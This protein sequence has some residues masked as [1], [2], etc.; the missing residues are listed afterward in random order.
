MSGLLLFLLAP[1]SG[2]LGADQAQVVPSTKSLPTII[3]AATYPGANALV[4]SDSVARPIESQL[5]GLEKV[6]HLISRCT[7][8][9]KYTLLVTLE[10]GVDLNIAQVLVQNR[11]SLAVPTLPAVIQEHG[12]TIRKHS[13]GAFLF[14]TLHSPDASL[15]ALYLSN[16]AIIHV[17]DELARLPE[18]A[19]V[20]LLGARDYAFRV[21]LD[22]Q[23]LAA[24]SLT[25]DDV[26]K[27]LREL[28]AQ[29]RGKSEA[30]EKVADA[31]IKTG[32]GGRLVRLRDV[33]RV[34][35]GSA[36][37]KDNARLDGKP[38]VVLSLAASSRTNERALRA[39]VLKRMAE[40]KKS[41]PPGIDYSINIDLTSDN[42]SA[43]PSLILA[44][45]VVP[46]DASPKRTEEILDRYSAVLKSI[47]SVQ[48]VMTLPEN[49]FDRFAGGPCVVAILAPNVKDAERAQLAQDIRRQLGKVTGAE[50]R[51]RDLSGAGGLQRSGFP[52][53]LAIR[54]PESTGVREY[55]EKL[56]ERLQRTRKLSDI[57]AAT[58][59]TRLVS[60][61]VDRSK[62]AAL[63]VDVKDVFS[64]LE[65]YMGNAVIGDVN[66]F[67]RT[68]KVEVQLEG[69][70]AD[71]MA[72]LKQ[73]MVRNN[74]GQMVSLATLV[75]MRESVGPLHVDRLDGQP[76]AL[77]S[78][79]LSPGV[80]LAEA[81][82]LCEKRAEDVRKE[83]RLSTEYRLVWLNEM[84]VAKP[85]AED[86]NIDREPAP[87]EVAVARPTIREVTNYADFT[88]RLDAVEKVDLRA[89]VTGY[90]TNMHFKEGATVKKGD[91]LFEI[92]PRP[93]QAQLEQAMGQVALREASLKLALATHERD[94]ALAKIEKNSVSPQQ[95]DRDKA[96]V[97]EAK[98]RLVAAKASADVHKLNVDFTKITA[99][100]S[101]QIGRAYMTPGNLII[102]DQTPLATIVSLDPIHVH[103]DV[104][105]RTILK[106]R[107]L[108]D[109]EMPVL[110]SLA[111]EDAFPRK[112]VINFV[113]HEVNPETGTLSLRAVLTN[114]DRSLT[115]GMFA[116]VR[117]PLGGPHKALLVPESAI[118]S[119]QGRQFVYVVGER[120]KV[121][122]RP[123][124]VGALHEKLRVIEK[125]LEPDDRFVIRGSQ[126]LRSGTTIK[127][128]EADTKPKE[129]NP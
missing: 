62:A 14:V 8:D 102:Q 37:S 4:V 40:L 94:L 18:M 43:T 80:S 124:V 114:Q 56:A 31:V 104:D 25:A 28:N 5:N 32:D 99:P 52:V 1:P 85:L 35:L 111:T 22:P 21:W 123:V 30:A 51:L 109:K 57:L 79:N 103:F 108:R 98:A 41:F 6:R 121:A 129:P 97:E 74:K 71:R 55:A 73:L 17:R 33:A 95:L 101:G 29:N 10:P 7:N 3:V 11:V 126:N 39:A 59:Q 50:L 110:V 125:G 9:G 54:G 83:L 90:L 120:N 27:A 16:Y 42:R 2:V 63:G 113:S 122:V 118:W 77:V 61:D 93:Y 34:E 72:D 96:A 45:P 107:S 58:P 36:A 15:D 67:G 89:R 127:P 115:P 119:D 19:T 53:E 81:R 20:S 86:P 84:P 66:Q 69:R 23:R 38:V 112:G 78:A 91:L 60:V 47:K 48:H 100:I 76:A 64:A 46:S 13:A 128:V 105:E 24:L 44:E 65:V 106:L 26:S 70:T 117:L 88:G 92:D 12:I 87:P 49:P 82:S 75:E 68:W 116:R